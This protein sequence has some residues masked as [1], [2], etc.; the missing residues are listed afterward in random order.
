MGF[1]IFNLA[2]YKSILKILSTPKEA[3]ENIW[4]LDLSRLKEK[5]FNTFVLDVDN[6]ILSNYQ[7]NL[8]LQHLNWI[9]KCKD[10]GFSVYILSNNRS[11]K[12]I[13]KVCDQVN[14]HGYFMAF[15]PFPFT[16]KRLSREYNF[17]LKKTVVVGDQLLK[18]V[19]LANWVRSYS[20]LVKPIDKSSNYIDVV[21]RRFENFLL[22][23]FSISIPFK[24]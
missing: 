12:R 4:D 19:F 20:V 8:S 2:E 17:S 24:L 11:R 1:P 7:K 15:K 10:N 22:K 3:H 5:G 14:S 16:L 21:Q 18:D 13:H 9:Q 6:T 23:S